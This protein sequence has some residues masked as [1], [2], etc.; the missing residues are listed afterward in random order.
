M[1]IRVL[2]A[3]DHALL[4]AGIRALI[5][6]QPGLSVVG[7]ASTMQETVEAVVAHAPDV[8]L[9]DLSLGDG[10]GV[11]TIRQIL[12][13]RPGTRV[14]VVTMHEERAYLRASL[15]AGASGY[16]LKRSP[17]TE[18]VGAVRAVHGGE[19]FVDPSLAATVLGE[20]LRRGDTASEGPKL[21][22]RE[23][24]VL[25]MIAAG[26]T[27]PDVA[28]R[29]GVSRKTVET[30]RARLGEKLGLRTRTELVRYALAEGIVAGPA[31]RGAEPFGEAT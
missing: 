28:R 17:E 25:G 1:S 10:G 26:H 16:V 19:T 15:G 30:Y 22:M 14:L 2:I 31:P 29:L 18:L 27:V 9:L 3:D 5:E 4:R 6:R 11:E 7:E 20:M 23:R 24:E 21:S 8:V 12:E 13:A